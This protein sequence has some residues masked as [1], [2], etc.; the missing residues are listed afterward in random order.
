MIRVEMKAT[1]KAD[2][3]EMKSTIQATKKRWRLTY[4]RLQPAKKG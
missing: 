4:K 2:Q 3:E 1:I